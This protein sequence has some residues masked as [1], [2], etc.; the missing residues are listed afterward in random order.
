[1]ASRWLWTAARDWIREGR[2]KHGGPAIGLALGGGFARGIAHVG[3][4]RV[5]E[6]HHVPVDYVGGVSAGAIVAAA[7]ASGANSYEIENVARTM[8]FK[9]VARWKLSHLGLAGSE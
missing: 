8:T 1:M 4:L 5:M 3:V 2:P 6:E 7:W 9:D